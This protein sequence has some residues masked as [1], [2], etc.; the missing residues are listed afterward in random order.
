MGKKEKALEHL[1][2][3]LDVWKDADPVYKQAKKAR[4]KLAEW[5]VSG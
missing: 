2:I 3:T 5:E 1:K 4:E